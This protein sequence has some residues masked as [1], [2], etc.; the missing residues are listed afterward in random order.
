MFGAVHIAAWNFHFPSLTERL[1]WRIS[2]IGVIVLLSLI[3]SLVFENRLSDLLYKLV[4]VV[5][6]IPYSLLRLYMFIEMFISLR[7]SP[8][9]VYQ[10]P[11]W[12]QYFPSFG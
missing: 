8:A 6:G 4:V 10:T 2:S 7:P 3:D 12:S 1:L 5:V 9:S 11:Q